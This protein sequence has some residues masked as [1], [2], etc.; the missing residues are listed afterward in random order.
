[1]E[2]LEKLVWWVGCHINVVR[3][4]H[5]YWKS[6]NPPALCQHTRLLQVLSWCGW[7]FCWHTL[8]PFESTEHHLSPTAS[9]RT[10]ADHIHPFVSA[11]Y[12]L[13]MTTS[14]RITSSPTGFF[15]LALHKS[16]TLSR[17]QSYRNLWDGGT[18][19]RCHPKICINCVTVMSIWTKI[20]E[21]CLQHL[22]EP[23]PWRINAVLKLL[24]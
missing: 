13:L 5:K 4:W 15:N 7:C 21:D 17:S 6:M 14:S 16:S 2:I 19:W 9:L 10:V 23:V 18:S 1:M 8:V 11:V 3:F 22:V 20:S 12:H 24:C